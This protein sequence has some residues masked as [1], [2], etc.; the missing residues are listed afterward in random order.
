MWCGAVPFPLFATLRLGFGILLLALSLLLLIIFLWL[1]AC[2]TLPC[3]QQPYPTTHPFWPPLVS[4]C[5][6]SLLVLCSAFCLAFGQVFC[7]ASSSDRWFV[8]QQL[9]LCVCVC[10]LCVIIS[11]VKLD[12]LAN[13]ASTV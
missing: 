6:C 11:F 10:L 9:S 2:K 7:A 4:L 12:L 13:A 3:F 1:S 5:H 8:L